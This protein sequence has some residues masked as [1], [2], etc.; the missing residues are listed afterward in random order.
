LILLALGLGWILASLG[1]FIRDIGQVMPIVSQILF[2]VTPIFYKPESIPVQFQFLA[3]INPLAMI[4]DNFR[5]ILIW[6]ELFTVRDWAAW[7]FIFGIVAIL[8]Y[9]W[10]MG[11]K[12]GFA[13]VL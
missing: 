7:T 8:G 2:F 9:V 1:V 12:K 10:F 13:D 4:V 3:A 5:K 6:S 11:T